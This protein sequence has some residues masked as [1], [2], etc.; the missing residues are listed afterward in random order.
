MY[1]I[2]RLTIIKPPFNKEGIEWINNKMLDISSKRNYFKDKWNK[3]LI[4]DF[5]LV[6][7]IEV[8]TPKIIKPFNYMNYIGLVLY[9]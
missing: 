1:K 7:E 4:N 6:D 9:A 8:P 5:K 2:D 3:S